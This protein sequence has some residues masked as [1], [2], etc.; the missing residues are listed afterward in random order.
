MTAYL[1]VLL[2]GALLPIQAGINGALA[3]YLGHPLRA[4]LVSFLVGSLFLLLLVALSAKGPWEGIGHAP[5]WAWL[6][7]LGGALYVW[8]IVALA[9]RLGAL[10]SFALLILGQTLASLL[11]DHLGLLYPKHPVSPLRVLGLLLILLGVVLVRR[12]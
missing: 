8:T 12:F 9:P 6:G 10:F 3:Q 2:A 5:L 4:S 7:G 11:L 1:L